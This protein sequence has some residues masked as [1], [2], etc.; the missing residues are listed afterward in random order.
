MDPLKT[1]GKIEII[2]C[3]SMIILECDQSFFFLFV[4]LL[5]QQPII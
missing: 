5:V 2:I 4:C 1:R 3:D